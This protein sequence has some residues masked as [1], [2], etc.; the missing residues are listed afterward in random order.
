M[1]TD[2]WRLDQLDLH[3]YLARLGL[4]AQAPSRTALDELHEQHVRTFTFDN[5]D[6]LLQQHSGVALETVQEKFVVQRR[7]GYCFEHS[8]LLAAALERLGYQVLRRLARVHDAASSTTLG[9]THLVVEVVLDGL[10]LLC[11]PGFGMSLLRPIALVDGHEEVQ[12][13]WRF[14]ITQTDEPTAWRL[15]RDRGDA[16]ELVHTTDELKVVPED[17]VIGHH[18]TS[19]FPGSH[20]TRGLVAARHLPGRHITVTATTVTVRRPGL[21]TE[22][23]AL[24][25]GELPAWLDLLDAGLTGDETSRLL[26]RLGIKQVVASEVSP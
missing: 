13:G 5:V 15:Y 25:S 6:V 24:E 1:T 20:F 26:G 11:D 4:S 7:G 17:I 8:T 18:Y 12:D 19:T 16:W 14:R 21:P 10:R 2:V 3:A 9:R 22:H 23:R